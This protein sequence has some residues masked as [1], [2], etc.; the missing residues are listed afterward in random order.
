MFILFLICLIALVICIILPF[1]TAAA[2]LEEVL[3]FI[4]LFGFLS[5]VFA[6]QAL[7]RRGQQDEKHKRFGSGLLTVGAIVALA[8][9]LGTLASGLITLQIDADLV[10][11][12]RRLFGADAE[13]ARL[14]N[15]SAAQRKPHEDEKYYAE[16]QVEDAESLLSLGLIAIVVS[17]SVLGAGITMA[18]LG[19]QR[20]KLRR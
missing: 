15:A 12:Q 1:A 5:V 7:R 8:G 18:F 6:T 11:A 13:L 9:I 17:F 2:S 19:M 4:A 20:R 14:E 10:R 16:A 3:P